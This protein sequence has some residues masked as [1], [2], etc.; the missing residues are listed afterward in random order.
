[1]HQPTAVP[2]TGAPHVQVGD[3]G[4]SKEKIQT[5]VSGVTSQVG[6]T[7]AD[8]TSTAAL[9][10]PR[11]RSRHACCCGCHVLLAQGAAVRAAGRPECPPSARPSVRPPARPCSGPGPGPGPV[12]AFPSPA[13]TQRGT[14]PWTAPEIIRSPAAVTEKVDVFSFAI[15]MWELWTG[16]CCPC[17]SLPACRPAPALACQAA[18]SSLSACL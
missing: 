16:G 4:L 7:P 6:G 14:L 15:V 12:P 17:F 11:R 18:L 3:F 13:L 2:F 1:M 5:Y 10:L 8:L 9:L